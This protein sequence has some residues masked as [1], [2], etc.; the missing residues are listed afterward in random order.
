MGANTSKSREV[1]M[2]MLVSAWLVLMLKLLLAA[3]FEVRHRSND[4]KRTN[5]GE[6][7]SEASHR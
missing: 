3:A 2:E 4:D 7:R 1:D 6:G 5:E